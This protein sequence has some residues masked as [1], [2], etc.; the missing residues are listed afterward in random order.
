MDPHR[1]S[2]IFL[3]DPLNDSHEGADVDKTSRIWDD[4]LGQPQTTSTTVPIPPVSRIGVNNSDGNP[5]VIP[6]NE[7]PDHI[8][9]PTN[10]V[11][12]PN[13]STT[14]HAPPTGPSPA[15]SPSSPLAPSLDFT[16]L[17]APSHAAVPVS[18]R[19][20]SLRRSQASQTQQ[21]AAPTTILAGADAAPIAP[22]TSAPPASLSERG[23]PSS[24]GPTLTENDN[25]IQGDSLKPLSGHLFNQPSARSS[26]DHI[27]ELPVHRVSV[28]RG[29]EEFAALERRF[30]NL[31]Q[32]SSELQRQNTRRSSFST[33]AATFKKPEKTVSHQTAA[34]EEK[35][36]AEQE[37]FNLAGILHTG[38]QKND[39]AGIKHK[40]VGVIWEDLEVIGGGGM[41]INIRALQVFKLSKTRHSDIF[42]PNAIVEAVMVPALGLL[43]LVGY[44]PFAPKPKTIL[45]K[46]SGLLRP[47][48]MCLVL[49][50]PNS[51]CSTFL[52]T[53][54]NQR[55]GYMAVNGNVE[56]AGLG[57]K[58]MKKLYAG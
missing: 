25:A 45:H 23:S 34:D 49:G 30:S 11:S 20:S 2:G 58:E 17:A 6:S 47:G 57:W 32:N 46:T 29:R 54:A 38:R 53:I 31:S 13:T 44:K 27:T 15:A 39:E 8:G 52:K 12:P 55:D 24:S 7:F 41:R 43:G 51:G 28:R 4:G 22:I 19:T 56:Y 5:N 48:E 10:P 3:G 18:A 33:R 26:M 35:G 21:A 37:D 50:R 1:A 14:D 40:A 9:I 42:S 36:R 16:G